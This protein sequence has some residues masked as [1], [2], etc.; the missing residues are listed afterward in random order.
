M[1]LTQNI[2]LH[3]YSDKFPSAYYHML[4]GDIAGDR[5]RDQSQ[6]PKRAEVTGTT[7][8][9]VKGDQLMGLPHKSI[10]DSHNK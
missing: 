2:I 1:V 8:A 7:G 5:K 6:G 3:K 10:N 4:D 9:R